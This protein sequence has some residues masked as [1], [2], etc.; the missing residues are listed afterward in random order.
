ME[1]RKI[2]STD[3]EASVVAVGAWPMGGWMWGGTDEDD[4]IRAIHTAFDE[5]VNFI[6]T[7]P[8]YGFGDSEKV[9]GKAIKDRRDK[10][11]VA[12]KCGMVCTDTEGKFAFL[13]TA[14]AIDSDGHIPVS[15]YQG[16]ESIR[17]EVERSLRRLGTDYIDVLQTHWQDETT[18]ISETM[19]TMVKLKEEG[20]IRAI[21]ACNASIDQLSEYLAG[22]RLDVDQEQYSMLDRELEK[23]QLGYC[24]NHD[25]SVW[26]YSPIANGLLSGK[27]GPDRKF[28]EGDLRIGSPRFSVENRKKVKSMLDE[29][30][31]IAENH[32]ISI[33]QLVIAWTL[34]QTGVTHVLCG[35]RNT[36][37]AKENAR[38]GNVKLTDDELS[39]IRSIVEKHGKEIE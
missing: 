33:V 12:T 17:T 10:V 39:R 1:Y 2:G 15:I 9:V 28:N 3:M 35:M 34:A 27:M 20:K 7:A 19:E 11:I 32:D 25:I 29:L 31:P 8:I 5:G 30:N 23:E 16:G 24:R 13:S 4:S 26:P 36:E 38:A 14:Q 21:G 6:D 37:Q 18:P 22:G